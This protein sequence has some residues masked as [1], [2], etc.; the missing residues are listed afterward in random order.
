MFIRQFYVGERLTAG[1]G[2]QGFRLRYGLP[3]DPA[4][5]E[6]VTIA[7]NRH[8]VTGRAD[9]RFD[10]S[11]IPLVRLDATG[12][13]YDHDEIEPTG[14]IGSHFDLRTQTFSATARTGIGRHMGAFGGSGFFKQYEAVGEEALTPPAASRSLGVYGFHDLPLFHADTARAIHLH[15]GARYDHTTVESKPGDPRFDPP[16]ERRFGTFSGSAGLVFPLAGDARL[17]LNVARA[18]R[19]PTVEE[20]FSNGVHVAAGTFDRGNPDLRAETNTGTEVVLRARTARLTAQLSG[21]Y[22]RIDDYIL[23]DVVGDT[24]VV[25]PEDPT[26]IDT[27]PLVR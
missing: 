5:P 21:Y 10:G 4:D 27:L 23:A 13:W 20:L 7:G 15:L 17:N 18:F 3:A 25:D 2:Y 11:A 12:Q 19:A 8:Q 9:L 1:I 14:E 24:A 6:S 22:N 26:V 16:R